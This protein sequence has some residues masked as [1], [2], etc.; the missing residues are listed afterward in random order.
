MIFP[1]LLNDPRPIYDIGM[2]QVGKEFIRIVCSKGQ[3]TL[4]KD[5]HF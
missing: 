5:N 2:W 3:V 4:T 1:Q